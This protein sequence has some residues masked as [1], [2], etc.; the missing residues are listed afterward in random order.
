MI[1]Q[2]KE[3]ISGN[4]FAQ[5]MNAGRRHRALTS[6]DSDVD[7]V[8]D[9]FTRALRQKLDSYINNA[10]ALRETA[11][12][13]VR[14]RGK[15]WQPLMM[16]ANGSPALRSSQ[17]DIRQ[18]LSE[19]TASPRTQR[20]PE[21]QMVHRTQVTVARRPKASLLDVFKNQLIRTACRTTHS[22]VRSMFASLSSRT[23]ETSGE[24]L[25]PLCTN[26]KQSLEQEHSA[27]PSSRRLDR[28]LLD[29]TGPTVKPVAARRVRPHIIQSRYDARA[30][31]AK[32]RA[33]TTDP[34]QVIESLKAQGSSAM[35]RMY[36]TVMSEFH[37]DPQSLPDDLKGVRHLG[38]HN[39]FNQNI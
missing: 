17:E 32:R 25:S 36:A 16:S 7:P 37:L 22:R 39:I 2:E 26:F 1:M 10:P 14:R 38:K 6:A 11:A 13:T 8:Q 23:P 27:S 5:E 28:K 9:N 18:R 19:S 35:D 21:L 33:P 15:R 34:Y 30:A 4:K 31:G 29:V 20:L 12:G 3:F 24:E